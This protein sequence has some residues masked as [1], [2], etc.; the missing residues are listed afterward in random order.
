MSQERPERARENALVVGASRG[1]GLEL[2]RQWL[3]RGY[4]VFAAARTRSLELEALASS[5][6]ATAEEGGALTF[7]PVDLR[8]ASTIEALGTRL[9]TST[10]SLHWVFN[11]AGVLHGEGFGPERKL[12]DLD[13]A[14]LQQVFAVNALAPVLLAQALLP[15]L[16]HRERSLFASLSARVG[17]ISDNRLGGWYAYRASKAAQNQFLKTLSLELRRRAPRCVVLALHPGTVDTALSRPFQRNV[18]PH[19]LFSVERAARQLI[20]IMDQA[21]PATSGSF[22]AWDGSEIPW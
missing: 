6:P 11:S 16:R 20:E 14:A 12:E 18:P 15:L 19:K 21:T 1:I 10:E 7:T 3:Q 5:Y 8:D 2:T 17:S 22:L 13:P 4:R 9:A